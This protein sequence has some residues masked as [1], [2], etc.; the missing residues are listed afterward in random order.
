MGRKGP[1]SKTDG[2]RS[3]GRGMG[4]AIGRDLAESGVRPLGRAGRG[5]GGQGEVDLGGR[6]RHGVGRRVSQDVR[7]R[8]NQHDC[9]ACIAVVLDNKFAE[10]TDII[11]YNIASPEV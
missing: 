7:E 8:L 2:G 3:G 9:H 5:A 1:R 4:W 6:S 11:G 10:I